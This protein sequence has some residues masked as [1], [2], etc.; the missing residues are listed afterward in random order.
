MHR[1]PGLSLLILAL[2]AAP[3]TADD[4]ALDALE[5]RVAEQQDELRRL[6]DAL[7]RL[8]GGE[9]APPTAEAPASD[10]A[11]PS[12]AAL[13]GP[14]V[15]AV[16][17]DTPVKLGMFFVESADGTHRLQLNGRLMLDG[18]FTG[19]DDDGFQV[20]RARVDFSGQVAKVLTFKLGLEFGRTSDAD[21]RDAYLNLALSEWLQVHAGQ[22]LV[23]FST[24]GLTSSNVMKLPER[25]IVVGSLASSREIGV[26]LHGRALGDAL[27]YYAAIFNGN[28]QNRASDDDDG[29]DLA[30]RLEVAPLASVL[31]AAS[32]RYTPPSR[33]A[34]RGPPDVR[35][36]GDQ[37]TRFLDY[38]T[39][40]NRHRARRERGSIDARVRAGPLEVKG[41]LLLDCWR[42][43]VSGTGARGDLL[44]WGWFVDASYVLTG[45]T[46][47]D[48]IDPTRPFYGQG[49]G[50]F[51][52]GAWEL[53]ARY[54]EFHA[55]AATLSAGF[56]VGARVARAASVALTWIP[57]KRVRALL[58]Y[59]YSAFDASIVNTEGRRRVDDHAVIVRIGLWF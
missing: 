29:K 58:S 54:E 25:P 20:R 53:S 11:P 21:L 14:R 13:E 38:D 41:E 5:R 49:P 24:E 8:R 9:P 40:N 35:T 56:A 18:R 2:G 23:P 55:D 7:T 50:G 12:R 37:L 16:G 59:T 36:V 19:R 31:L 33:D 39:A 44:N 47:Q 52:P 26:M 48:T 17:S 43:M 42:D 28:G 45:E 46:S 30:L 27:A 1:L 34:S 57:V 15:P 51:G 10:P 3:A 22:M 32:Y 4:P 6:Q